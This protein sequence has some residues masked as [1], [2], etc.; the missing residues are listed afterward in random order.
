MHPMQ[1]RDSLTN[2][3]FGGNVTS[4]MLGSLGLSTFRLMLSSLSLSPTGS[5]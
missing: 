1:P 4:R 5:T 3:S 2:M